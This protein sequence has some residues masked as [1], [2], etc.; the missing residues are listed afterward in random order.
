MGRKVRLLLPSSVGLGAG[1]SPE[2]FGAKDLTEA[3]ITDKDG[4]FKLQFRTV[5]HAHI[6][7]KQPEPPHF[8]LAAE[9]EK[10]S[11]VWGLDF[12]PRNPQLY[13]WKKDTSEFVSSASKTAEITSD[14]GSCRS[15]KGG[16]QMTRMDH[17]KIRWNGSDCDSTTIGKAD[18]IS[19]PDPLKNHIELTYGTIFSGSYGLSY[20]RSFFKSRF[21]QLEIPIGFD[22]SSSGWAVMGKLR[23][24]GHVGA[25]IYMGVGPQWATRYNE[26]RIVSTGAN[27]VLSFS[28]HVE[29][30][31]HFVF[32]G[33]WAT[34]TE[35]S[36][37]HHGRV[38]LRFGK[39]F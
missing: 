2:M 15:S 16:C 32:G 10:C 14:D 5:V 19:Y 30:K 11:K 36:Q 22:G 34:T 6:G 18:W 20:T 28:F 25:G 29:L 37:Q 27:P 4:K 26:G 35:G 1:E 39:A 21:L 17:V 24:L 12:R 38:V 23:L 3:A 13:E 31:N 33:G 9:G 7:M 8:I